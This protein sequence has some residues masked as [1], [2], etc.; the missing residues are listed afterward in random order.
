MKQDSLRNKKESFKKMTLGQD[1]FKNCQLGQTKIRQNQQNEQENIRNPLSS[2]HSNVGMRELKLP[3]TDEESP[4]CFQGIQEFT[5]Y[6]FDQ[7]ERYINSQGLDIRIGPYNQGFLMDRM[8]G[9]KTHS[10]QLA[11]STKKSKRNSSLIMKN[12]AEKFIG[13]LTNFQKTRERNAVNEVRWIGMKTI[14]SGGTKNSNFYQ[15]NQT[16]H[17]FKQKNHQELCQ[18]SDNTQEFIGKVNEANK[19]SRSALSKGKLEGTLCVMGLNNSGFASTHVPEKMNM[20]CDFHKENA[21]RYKYL[22]EHL[23]KI[24]QKNKTKMRRKISPFWV[25]S[26]KYNSLECKKLSLK[27]DKL[28]RTPNVCTGEK[29]EE[30]E[31]LENHLDRSL[32]R[33]E[34]RRGIQNSI[35]NE[36]ADYETQFSKTQQNF[37]PKMNECLNLSSNHNSNLISKDLTVRPKPLGVTEIKRERKTV[38]R[39]QKGKASA[40]G[41]KIRNNEAIHTNVLIPQRKSNSMI[42]KDEKFQYQRAHSN[43]SGS[44]ELKERAPEISNLNKKTFIS[45]MNIVDLSQFEKKSAIMHVEITPSKKAVKESTLQIK[46]TNDIALIDSHNKR[47]TRNKAETQTF[48]GSSFK[49]NAKN[50]IKGISHFSIHTPAKSSPLNIIESKNLFPGA[51]STV[52][53]DSKENSSTTIPSPLKTFLQSKLI[54]ESRKCAKKTQEIKVKIIHKQHAS[55]NKSKNKNE[56]CLKCG[57]VPC[58][59]KNSCQN[60]IKIIKAGYLGKQ[61]RMKRVMNI[62]N[63]DFTDKCSMMAKKHK[64]HQNLPHKPK[65]APS[66]LFKQPNIKHILSKVKNRHTNLPAKGSSATIVDSIDQNRLVIKANATVKLV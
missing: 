46:N 2:K 54:Q 3:H 50:K 36:T 41:K 10:T 26:K 45:H 60:N 48:N 5:K 57:K 33:E 37:H 56:L 30:N 13:H 61:N 49:T 16:T 53:K 62:I 6:D 59:Q 65:P 14:K 42:P 19:R 1:S 40:L 31:A 12:N 43:Y 47:S 52:Y 38:S 24:D 51:L 34:S 9:D 66:R 29:N 25:Q 55:F 63:K 39:L 7:Y 32:D 17:L 8:S 44:P 11:S 15:L 23:K 58:S 18:T 22:Q 21:I 4:A 35:Y 20:V 28:I 64:F 27:G